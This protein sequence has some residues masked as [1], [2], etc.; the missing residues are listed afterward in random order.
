MRVF[1]RLDDL[2]TVASL[3]KS[4]ETGR[5]VKFRLTEFLYFYLTPEAPPASMASSPTSSS[6]P[7]SPTRDRAG[8]DTASQQGSGSKSKAGVTLSVDIK[9]RKLDQ[10]LPGVVD[11]LLR[12]LDRYKPFGGVLS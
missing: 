10:H 12:D 6:T 1:E 4:R 8:S 11:A 7:T 3:F 2:L 9:K 5:E